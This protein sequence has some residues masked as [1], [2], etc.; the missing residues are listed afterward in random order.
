MPVQTR[1]L[2]KAASAYEQGRRKKRQL[3]EAPGFKPL[4]TFISVW[5]PREVR[6]AIHPNDYLD[7]QISKELTLDVKII[8]AWRT[9]Q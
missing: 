8:I 4:S 9:F 1:R 6:R 2:I 5:K 7:T 3:R